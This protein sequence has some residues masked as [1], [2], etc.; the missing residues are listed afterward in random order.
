MSASIRP[1]RLAERT[2]PPG[3]P[4]TEPAIRAVGPGSAGAARTE[5]QGSG[6][7]PASKAAIRPEA[8]GRPGYADWL[9]GELGAVIEQLELSDL[10][11]R[12]LRARWLDAVIWLEGKAKQAQRLH[13][14]LRL[15]IIIGG[16]IIPALVSLDLGSDRA[17]DMVRWATFSLSLL[18][19]ISAAI[20]GFFRYG[21]RWRHYRMLVERLKIEGWQFFQL[22]GPYAQQRSHAAAHPEFAARVEEIIKS[23]VQ[24]YITEVVREK[25]AAAE[26]ASARADHAEPVPPSG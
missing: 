13:Y 3:E 8:A 14:A 19:A 2:A 20:E 23:D 12:C 17:G 9:K 21:E 7:Q 25:Q 24:Q 18:V 6:R 22:S 16:V 11:K 5:D 1:D 15:L 26:Q 10:Q 4:T